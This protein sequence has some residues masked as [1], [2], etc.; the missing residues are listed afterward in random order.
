VDTTDIRQEQPTPHYGAARFS[1]RMQGPRIPFRL[2]QK[3]ASEC[4]LLVVARCRYDG[5][6]DRAVALCGRYRMGQA[7]PRMP[8]RLAGPGAQLP[9]VALFWA[10]PELHLF[11]DND[12]PGRRAGRRPVVDRL[13]ITERNNVMKRVFFM[14]PKG[15]A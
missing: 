13:H 14:G 15:G 2:S 12:L 10:A 3:F 7:Q 8:R 1:S 5:A 11:V 4:R 9:V 6:N